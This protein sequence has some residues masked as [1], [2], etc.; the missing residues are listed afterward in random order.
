MQ[1]V[2]ITTIDNPFN[3]FTDFED[4]YAFDVRLGHNSLALLDRIALSSEE[5]SE[6]DQ[7]I[8][9]ETAIDEIIRES[10]LLIYRKVKQE[11]D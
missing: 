4:W 10:P 9:Y 11:M 1:K 5:L 6:V 8:A 3:P 2:A 7:E